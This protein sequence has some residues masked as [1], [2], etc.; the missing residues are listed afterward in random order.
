MFERFMKLSPIGKL[1]VFWG[2]GA[3]SIIIYYIVNGVT[4]RF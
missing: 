1:W 2:I 4:P 3:V